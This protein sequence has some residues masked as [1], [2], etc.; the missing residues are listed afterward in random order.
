MY[1][2]LNFLEV[3]C[4]AREIKSKFKVMKKRNDI[5]CLRTKHTNRETRSF[6][7]TGQSYM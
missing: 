6:M 2:T 5:F 3:A 7:A 1:A 4:D